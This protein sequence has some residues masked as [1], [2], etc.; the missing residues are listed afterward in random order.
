M[1]PLRFFYDFLIYSIFLASFYLVFTVKRYTKEEILA[2]RKPGVEGPP[3]SIAH[4]L[5]IISIEP[6]EPT[7]NHPLE[8]DDITRLWHAGTHKRVPGDADLQ[9]SPR[10]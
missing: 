7:S 3:D 9:G 10:W 4:I 1:G 5:D 2:L 6:L 8:H